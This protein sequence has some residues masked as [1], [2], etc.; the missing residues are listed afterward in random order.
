MFFTR[1]LN[2]IEQHHQHWR[3]TTSVPSM[4]LSQMDHKL[5]H[6]QMPNQFSEVPCQRSPTSRCCSQTNF[7]LSSGV[8]LL[9]LIWYVNPI[10]WD[11]ADFLGWLL[12]F[13][14]C[15]KL[16]SN[17]SPSIQRFKWSR[18]RQGYLPAIYHHLSTRYNWCYHCIVLGST[19]FGWT[20]MVTCFLSTH[21]RC[22]N[23]SLYS[24]QIN[25]WI[26]WSECTGIHYA[27]RKFV[28]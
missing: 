3:S 13:Q 23:G 17:C 12:V 14:S 4:I 7:K 26:C 19:P 25:C 2:S 20:K 6:Q 5:L 16:S 21:A 11:F 10:L 27:N 1:L 15:R 8:C 9:S 28:L 24:S 18:H 22:F